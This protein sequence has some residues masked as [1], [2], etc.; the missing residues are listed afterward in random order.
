MNIQNIQ[1]AQGLL[2]TVEERLNSRKENVSLD[3]ETSLSQNNMPEPDTISPKSAESTN[4]STEENL[5]KVVYPP[6]FP[7]GNTQDIL[8]IEGVKLAGEEFK[9]VSAVPVEEKKANGQKEAGAKTTNA[10]GNT[11]RQSNVALNLDSSAENNTPQIKH[12][13]N[14]GDVLDLKI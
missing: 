1:V 3:N 4:V 10:M 12:E 6:F 9:S 14:P 7:L 5:M 8:S 11:T 13:T 2:N